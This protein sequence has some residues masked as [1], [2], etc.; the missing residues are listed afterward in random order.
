MPKLLL[1]TLLTLLNFAAAA[2]TPVRLPLN[3][4]TLY[5]NGAELHHAGEISLPAGTAE[6]RLVG[7][8]PY[9]DAN[10]LQATVSGAAL[11]AVER[12]AASQ[13]TSSTTPVTLLDSLR[14]AQA[15][16]TALKTEEV[17]LAAEKEFLQQNRQMGPIKPGRWMKEAQ[18]RAA[19]YSTRLGELTQREGQVKEVL[20]A[21]TAR[22]TALNQRAG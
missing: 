6:L 4:V 10:S 21:Q 2:Q 15:R 5:L 17:V 16:S 19:Y 9:A 12:V 20:L 3:A 18:R 13:L 8:S 1:A 7:I 11:D 22:L 14:A